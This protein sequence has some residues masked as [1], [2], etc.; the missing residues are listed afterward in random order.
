M[1]EMGLKT[2]ITDIKAPMAR[3]PAVKSVAE[4]I[5]CYPGVHALIV[6]RSAHWLYL[7]KVPLI[8]RLMSHLNRFFTQIEIHP[9]A[10]IGENFFID[11]GSGI[12]I[13][14]TS[15]I[16]DNVMMYHGV[17]LG[18]TGLEKG[19]RHP[20]IESNVVIGAGAILLGNIRIGHDSK[21]GAGSVVNKSF[22]PHS[23]IVGVPGREVSRKE[24]IYQI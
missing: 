22:P 18:G 5:L 19:K 12:V 4:V 24:G 10:T 1:P 7:R 14:E 15:E 9:G 23:T 17:T 16:G 11:H 3:D 21:I 13:G 20:T 8:P 6:H 2:L